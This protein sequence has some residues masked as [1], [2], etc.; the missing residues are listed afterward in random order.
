MRKGIFVFTSSLLIILML[1]GCGV[2][3]KLGFKE[4]YN[5]ELHP[6]SSIVMNEEEAQ[7]ITDKVPMYLYFSNEDNTKLLLEVRYIP[8]SE[9]KKS[10]SN[11]ASVVVRELI[12]GPQERKDAKSLI[13]EGAD[14]RAPVKI[15]A[16]VATVDLTKEFVSKHPGGK[17]LEQLTVYSIVNSLTEIKDINKVRFLINGKEQKEFKGSLQFDA[18]FPRTPSLISKEVKPQ[19]PSSTDSNKE[20]SQKDSNNSDSKET[21]GEMEGIIGDEYIEFLE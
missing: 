20:N 4:A 7:K 16:G 5:D 6:V 1:T 18:P 17:E 9:A 19:E 11:L 14:L 8:A 10:V 21:F 15:E 3:E 13:P 2:L 12:K